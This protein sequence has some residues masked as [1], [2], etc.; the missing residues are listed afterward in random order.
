[1]LTGKGRMRAATT[2]YLQVLDRF[3]RLSATLGLQRRP[4]PLTTIQ[5][6]IKSRDTS[7]PD[8]RS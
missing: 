4:K 7:G 3:T 8:D 5:E 2:V 1:V 6:F